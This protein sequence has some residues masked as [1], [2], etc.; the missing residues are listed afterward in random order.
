M[1]KI[2]R[3][4]LGLGLLVGIVFTLQ[5]I[6]SVLA[7]P[8][9]AI[10]D[11]DSTIEVKSVAIF[12]DLKENGD[13][14]FIIEQDIPYASEPT[15]DPRDAFF[16]GLHDGTSMIHTA[17]IKFYNHSMSSI[18]LDATQAITGSFPNG[19]RIFISANPSL[20][21]VT[22]Q[23]SINL[24]I[25]STSIKT[26]LEEET[27]E[28]LIEDYIIG[29]LV[30][31]E[32]SSGLSYL[33]NSQR[34]NSAGADIVEAVIPFIRLEVPNMFASFTSS[35]IIPTP[36]FLKGGEATYTANQG[37]R[38]SGSLETLGLLVAGKPGLG[39]TIGTFLYFILIFSVMGAVLQ[40]TKDVAATT[41]G[42]GVP[43]LLVGT[44]VGIIPMSL[45]F[46]IFFFIVIIFGVVFIL[47][48]MG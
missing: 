32:G 12:S 11:P 18:Y 29:L 24:P 46:G 20:F 45:V 5:S 23:N 19:Y 44:V 21:T 14:L 1:G 4:G 8:M 27:V 13:Q 7:I 6:S 41:V 38:L 47:G 34:I 2:K 22:F 42:A 25:L 3:I 36:T 43:M 31:L 17:T 26:P 15:A 35:M 30:N 39:P 28:A 48:R 40:I 9:V 16:V 37:A 10:A 33:T